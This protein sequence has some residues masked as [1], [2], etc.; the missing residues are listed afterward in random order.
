MI[1]SKKFRATCKGC[2][3]RFTLHEYKGLEGGKYSDHYC[4]DPNDREKLYDLP[5]N[6]EMYSNLKEAKL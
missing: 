5:N 6:V 4:K 2:K 1:V 3:E